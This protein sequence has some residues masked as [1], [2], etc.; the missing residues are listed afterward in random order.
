MAFLMHNV[1]NPLIETPSSQRIL[2]RME[3]TRKIT[4]IDVTDYCLLY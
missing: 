4:P 2:E 1:P 3:M